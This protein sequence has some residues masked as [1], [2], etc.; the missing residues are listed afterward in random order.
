MQGCAHRMTM[1]GHRLSKEHPVGQIPHQWLDRIFGCLK[2]YIYKKIK[3]LD[4]MFCWTE[5]SAYICAMKK[6]LLVGL[7]SSIIFLVGIFIL[8]TIIKLFL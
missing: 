8:K 4:G 1:N 5:K 2:Q 7:I 6:H 3:K